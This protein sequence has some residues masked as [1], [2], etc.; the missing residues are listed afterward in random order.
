MNKTPIPILCPPNKRPLYVVQS[1]AGLPHNSKQE[2]GPFSALALLRN[3]G[4]A[5]AVF[6]YGVY[7]TIYS[8]LQ[9]SLSTIFVDIYGVTGLVAGLSYIPFGVACVLASNLTG[10]LY[11]NFYATPRSQTATLELVC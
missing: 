7:Y 1:D 5:L 2:S 9:A 6:C 3:R 11:Q 8:C 10:I 4:T